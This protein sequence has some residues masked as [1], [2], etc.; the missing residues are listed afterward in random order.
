ML[1][2]VTLLD[3]QLFTKKPRINL[4]FIFFFN[5][6]QPIVFAPNDN[7]LLSNQ[8]INQFLV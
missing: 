7:S 8:D 6:Y 1:L 5:K 3:P 2:S 4:H